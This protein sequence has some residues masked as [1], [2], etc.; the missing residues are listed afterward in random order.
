MPGQRFSFVLRL[1]T[2]TVRSGLNSR[3][4][5]RGSL[6]LVDSDQVRYFSSLD[7]IP[8]ILREI[9]GWSDVPDSLQAKEEGEND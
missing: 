6:Q 5:P 3:P 8:E 9:T 2:E 7:K 4:M 1:W